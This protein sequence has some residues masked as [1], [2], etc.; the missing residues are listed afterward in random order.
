MIALGFFIAAAYLIRA[1]LSGEK[2]PSNP[3]KGLTLEWQTPS[4]P[5]HDN[6]PITPVVNNWPY[7][8]RSTGA[9]VP[10]EGVAPISAQI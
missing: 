3:W 2:A 6:F 8:Y 5:P 1:I 7:E 9:V 4:P 10:V